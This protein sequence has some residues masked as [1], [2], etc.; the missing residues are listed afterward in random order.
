MS[1]WSCAP[2]RTVKLPVTPM[3][4]MPPPPPGISV[5]RS[6]TLL[7]AV[8]APPALITSPE[9]MPSVVLPNA[10]QSSLPPMLA[11]VSCRLP[12]APCRLTLPLALT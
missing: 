4:E 3:V 1:N 8:I 7:L 2:F 12:P 6:W 10:D 11:C 9:P 5:P